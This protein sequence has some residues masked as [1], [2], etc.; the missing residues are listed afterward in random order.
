MSGMEPFG[1]ALDAELNA[2]VPRPVKNTDLSKPE[3]RVKIF[4]I[5]TNEELVIASDTER[6]VLAAKK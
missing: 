6:L 5:P 1:I 4:L 2:N 3:S